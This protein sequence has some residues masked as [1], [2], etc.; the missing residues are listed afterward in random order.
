MKLKLFFFYILLVRQSRCCTFDHKSTK[1]REQGES[2]AIFAPF[3]YRGIVLP[4]PAQDR[5]FP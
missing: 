3:T 2:R 5:D 1:I 4:F